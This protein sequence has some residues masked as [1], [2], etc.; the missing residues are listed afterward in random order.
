MMVIPKTIGIMK[1]YFL[2]QERSHIRIIH[3]SKISVIINAVIALGKIGMGIYSLSF[4]VCVNGLYNL[5]ICLAKIIA[6]KGYSE[7]VG[8]PI[9]SLNPLKKPTLDKQRNKN[10]EFIYSYLVGIIV[11]IS[12]ILYVIGSVR[13]FYGERGNIQYSGFMMVAVSVF[14][15][16]ELIISL[17]GIRTTRKNGEP[18]LE[19]IKKT[20]FISSL[21]AFVLVQTAILSRPGHEPNIYL[22]TVG[23][24]LGIA[25]VFISIH[26]IVSIYHNF[27]KLG[28]GKQ[29]KQ[30][31]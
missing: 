27:H 22:D 1:N 19:A 2:D 11:L 29:M 24:A 15:V 7:S 21:I 31:I 3:F 20:C 14:A 12:S 13:V 18:I 26:M 5:G 17:R 16:A 25:S 10:R 28:N 9:W 8:L 30:G 4:F 6:I 23:V